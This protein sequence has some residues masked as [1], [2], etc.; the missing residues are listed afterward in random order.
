MMLILCE[1]R[2]QGSDAGDDTPI[3]YVDKTIKEVGM[4]MI[5]VGYCCGMKH[6]EKL[7]F[8]DVGII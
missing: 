4:E 8:I 6:G 7:I 5:M 2:D 3:A 1:V